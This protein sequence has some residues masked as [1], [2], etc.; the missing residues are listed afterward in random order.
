[1]IKE[2]NAQTIVKTVD[3]FSLLRFKDE[4]SPKLE[5]RRDFFDLP[6]HAPGVGPVGGLA[7]AVCFPCVPSLKAIKTLRGNLC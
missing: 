1:M 2:H 4:T 3:M 7:P 6:D 5:S